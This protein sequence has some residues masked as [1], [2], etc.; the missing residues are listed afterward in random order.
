MTAPH[1][2]LARRMAQRL[3]PE[4][5]RDPPTLVERVIAA[6]DAGDEPPTRFNPA[7]IALAFAAF[8]VSVGKAAWDIAKDL[9]EQREKSQPGPVQ[10]ARIEALEQ[11]V[12]FL[13]GARA[14]I[15]RPCLRS[16]PAERLRLCRGVPGRASR[17]PSA[18]PAAAAS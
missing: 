1:E 8:V 3:A 13:E 14:Q 17:G 9:R 4:I 12:A 2:D 11:E 5:D 15:H 6:G 10:A 18:A 16:P 7:T